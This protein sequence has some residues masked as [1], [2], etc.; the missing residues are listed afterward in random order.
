MT[1]IRLSCKRALYQ[2]NIYKY[3]SRQTDYDNLPFLKIKLNYRAALNYKF[4][5]DFIGFKSCKYCLESALGQTRR[6]I[7]KVA[8]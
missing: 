4:T 3:F 1:Y 7:S 6:K 5:T 2:S 8:I